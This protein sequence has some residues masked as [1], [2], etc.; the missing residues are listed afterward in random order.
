MFPFLISRGS[1]IAFL[2][3]TGTF[4]LFAQSAAPVQAKPADS[5]VEMMGVNLHLTIA[6]S[7]YFYAFD[8]IVKPRLKELGV[9]HVRD[10]LRNVDPLETVRG[11]S[12]LDRVKQL[13]A[14]GV[15]FVF[16]DTQ[17]ENMG[18][19]VGYAT[20]ALPYVRI[21][22]GPNER[23]MEKTS[24]Y[25]GELF[26]KGAVDFERA[27]Y[28]ALKGDPRTARIPYATESF[29]HTEHVQA[30]CDA[31]N[32]PADFGDLGT[33]H[34]Y[35]G[36]RPPSADLERTMRDI[37]LITGDRPLVT[38]ETGYHTDKILS[39]FAGVSE[40]AA[41]KY[42]ARLP[43]EYL[44]RHIELCMLYELIDEPNHG[45]PDHIEPDNKEKHFGLL[46]SNGSE[47]P[48][49]I[50]LKRLLALFN[51]PGP[52]FTPRTVAFTSDAPADV[53]QS[54]LAKRDGR[55]Y[56][57]LWH[58]TTTYDV[59]TNIDMPSPPVR[60]TLT[61]TDKFSGAR[62]YLPLDGGEPGPIVKMTGRLKVDVPDS[63]VIVELIP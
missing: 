8:S 22:E 16:L 55:I 48:S 7:P 27:T 44:N 58:D 13:H 63:V 61:L 28:K 17:T 2:F 20:A 10:Y 42:M 21:I 5:L 50:V 54:V 11:V 46:H 6:G 47:K 32:C 56:I 9:R 36:G 26:P 62:V 59:K 23:D 29:A 33:M 12:M 4:P 14:Q 18:K 25:K 38:T 39:S 51:D 60:V 3:V 1:T 24:I 34:S 45:E 57:A 15:D 19:L 37:R 43:F 53:H 30:F 35:A 49:F 31:A 41:G 52:A 40:L